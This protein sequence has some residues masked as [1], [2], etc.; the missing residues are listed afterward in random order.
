MG[1]DDELFS[2]PPIVWWD[3]NLVF[4]EDLCRAT[5]VSNFSFLALSRMIKLTPQ[6]FI[7]FACVFVQLEEAVCFP[8]C[9]P[10]CTKSPSKQS[11]AHVCDY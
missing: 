4:S 3:F 9:C 11:F 2:A 7:V 6:L 5:M 8:D 10:Q 1:V